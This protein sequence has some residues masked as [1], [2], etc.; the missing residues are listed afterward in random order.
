MKFYHATTLD[1]VESILQDGKIK[2]GWDGMIYLCKRPE[3]AARFVIIRGEK[4][5]VVIEVDLE[6]EKVKESADHSEKF[7]GCK[8]YIYEEDI[9]VC[10][11]ENVKLYEKAKEER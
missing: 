2:T 10:G 5:A 8:A 3:E 9:E 1:N 11:E 6:E 7:F 4:T